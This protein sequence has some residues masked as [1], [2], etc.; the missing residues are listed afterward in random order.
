M[1]CTHRKSVCYMILIPYFIISEEYLLYEIVDVS[2]WPV[3]VNDN[4]N[5]AIQWK[6][7]SVRVTRSSWSSTSRVNIHFSWSERTQRQYISFRF[8]V[9]W[10]FFFLH[11]LGGLWQW[12][13]LRQG[14]QYCWKLYCLSL[15]RFEILTAALLKIQS[16]TRCY[17][18]SAG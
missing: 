12:C 17:A 15:A 4:S 18:M 13:T 1:C 5:V 14:L 9:L 8:S 11:G 3:F 7:W 6:T 2:K 10:S 16:H